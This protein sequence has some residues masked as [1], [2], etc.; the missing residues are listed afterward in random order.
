MQ[1]DINDFRSRYPE[2]KPYIGG[3]YARAQKHKCS[4][5]V[6][7]ESHYLPESSSIHKDC[8]AWYASDHSRLTQ[9]ERVWISTCDIITDELPED[10]PNHAH[11]IWKYGYRQINHFGPCFKDYRE[12]FQYTVFYNFYLRP[13]DE[14][15]S[16]KDLCTPEDNIIANSYFMYMFEHYQPD[17]IIFLSRL[18]FDSCSE[19]ERLEIPIAGAPHPTCRWWNRKCGKYG[20]RFGRDLVQDGLVGMDWTWTR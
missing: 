7:G 9:E 18:A 13:A 2:M 8:R 20:N 17:G 1:F 6:I 10:F 16:F 14:G 5:L 15:K 4:L 3:E 12:I 19:K 11:G